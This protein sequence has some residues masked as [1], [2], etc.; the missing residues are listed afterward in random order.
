MQQE[1]PIFLITVTIMI[2][3][4]CK[5]KLIIASKPAS[6]LTVTLF[7][8]SPYEND[9]NQKC[10]RGFRPYAESVLLQLIV[11]AEFQAVGKLIPCCGLST[12]QVGG[13]YS[14]RYDEASQFPAFRWQNR[15]WSPEGR[16]YSPSSN[17]P[18]AALTSSSFIGSTNSFKLLTYCQRCFL[19][20]NMH[21]T[22]MIQVKDLFT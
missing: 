22:H 20:K 4:F 18:S 8:L 1:T 5:I 13:V 17:S 19:I 7:S 14:R 3:N 15:W 6:N 21:K 2:L 10:K 16:C 12:E 9:C 11:R